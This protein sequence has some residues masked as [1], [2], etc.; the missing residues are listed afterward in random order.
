M[1]RTLAEKESNERQSKTEGG[2]RKGKGK[3]G[4]GRGKITTE[5]N[6]GG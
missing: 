5:G 1:C 6:G 4:V 3:D 2:V